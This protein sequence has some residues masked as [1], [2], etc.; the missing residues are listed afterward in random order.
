MICHNLHSLNLDWQRRFW[1]HLHHL[2]MVRVSEKR[3]DLL[4]LCISSRWRS[5]PRPVFYWSALSNVWQTFCCFFWFQFEQMLFSVCF[6]VTEIGKDCIGLRISPI[7]FRW[8]AATDKFSRWL[9]ISYTTN[10]I[11]IV[12]IIFV[13]ITE[14]T[15]PSG[16]SCFGWELNEL[17]SFLV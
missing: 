15:I 2:S 4:F 16:R 7:Q 6:Q 1:V 13:V 3:I 5:F 8:G 9:W 10:V 17:W 12:M 11:L 14:T